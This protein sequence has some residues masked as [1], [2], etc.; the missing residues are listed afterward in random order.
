MRKLV[1]TALVILVAISATINGV[2]AATSD[3]VSVTATPAYISMSVAPDTWTVNGI[4]GSGVI[5]PSTTYYSNPLGDTTAPANPVVDGGCTFTL[6]NTSS[7]ATDVVANWSNFTGVGDTMANSNTGS[8]AAATFGAASYITGAAWPGGKVTVKTAGSD[9]MINNL[10]ATTNK[11]FGFQIYTRT[12]VW[13]AA[14]V[15]SGTITIT[16]SLH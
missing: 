12:N 16:S 6:T 2:W 7:V 8:P 4:T 3:T 1:I 9:D 5:E 13:T 10:A 11:K 14:N 15:M